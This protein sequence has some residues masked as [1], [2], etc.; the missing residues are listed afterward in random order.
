MRIVDHGGTLLLRDAPGLHWLLGLLF[1]GVGT[2]FVLGPLGLFTNAAEV[3]W[4]VR[5]FSGLLGAAGVATGLWVLA[6][7]PRSTLQ[8]DRSTGRLHLERRGL[9]GREASAWPITEITD[10]RLT[11]KLDD[12]GDPVFQVHLVLRNGAV[13]PVSRLWTH[14]RQQADAVVD[15]LR[16][17]L[18]VPRAGGPGP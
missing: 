18:R 2:V 1:V 14:G 16:E 10:V 7:S 4:W 8:I 15:R 6:G 5:V 11:E 13:V 12:E 9:T 3:A 17:A